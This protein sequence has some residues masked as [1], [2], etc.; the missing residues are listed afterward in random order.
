LLVLLLSVVVSLCTVTVRAQTLSIS[1]SQYPQSAPANARWA[2]FF[3]DTHRSTGV[4]VTGSGSNDVFR[5][6]DNGVSWSFSRA[7]VSMRD[8]GGAVATSDGTYYIVGGAD[9]TNSLTVFRDVWK[10]IDGGVTFTLATA[11]SAFTPR[12]F[13]SLLQDAAGRML[14]VGGAAQSS[15]SPLNDVWT[16][17]NG[18]TWTRA[19]AV[20]PFSK[21]HS[22]CATLSADGYVYLAAGQTNA[23]NS[24]S[25]TFVNDVYR[26]PGNGNYSNAVWQKMSATAPFTA[27]RSCLLLSPSAGVLLLTAGATNSYYAGSP[28]LNDVWYSSDSGSTWQQLSAA[29]S[30]NARSNPY[31]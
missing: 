11:T 28:T 27:R 2:P 4:V 21:R 30:F 10:S 18:A 23:P 5:S 24:A 22:H 8:S 9:P 6:S 1:V 29:A 7:N 17:T 14:I 26:A 15:G 3:Y 25:G 16:S 19:T 31:V 13:F 20:T 12:L